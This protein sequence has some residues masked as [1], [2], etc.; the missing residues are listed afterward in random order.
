MYCIHY[1]IFIAAKYLSASVT[2][3]ILNNNVNSI[4]CTYYNA[5]NFLNVFNISTA[6]FRKS[7]WSASVLSPLCK[8]TS[9][10]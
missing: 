7:L 8:Y 2:N 1:D 6:S 5:E 10:S 3:H 9:A 4:T